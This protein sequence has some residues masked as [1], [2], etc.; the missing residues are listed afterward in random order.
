MFFVWKGKVSEESVWAVTNLGDVFVWDST[1][2]ESAQLR[3]DDCYVQKFD[4]SGKECPIKVALHVGC[5][6]GT[7]LTLTGWVTFRCQIKNDSWRFFSD[8]SQ[9]FQWQMTFLKILPTIDTSVCFIVTVDVSDIVLVTFNIFFTFS[10]T[11][12]IVSLRF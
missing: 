11:I 12:D 9:F 2:V 4:L 8:I 3:E 5:V 1:Q 10:M 6:P 7:T